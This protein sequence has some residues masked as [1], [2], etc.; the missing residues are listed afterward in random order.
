MSG[1]VPKP[2]ILAAIVILAIAQL[3]VQLVFFLH[4]GAAPEQRN[5]T[6]VF[7]L[8][9]LLI[10]TIVAGSLWVIGNAKVNMMPMQMSPERAISR[11]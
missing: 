1:V 11:D 10:A 7:L 3:L 8:T 2:M 5:N 9:V 6:V 4:L